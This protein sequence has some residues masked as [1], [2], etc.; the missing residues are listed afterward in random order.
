MKDLY[1]VLRDDSKWIWDNLTKAALE[2]VGDNPEF[3][4]EQPEWAFN[5]SGLVE[6]ITHWPGGYLKR[7]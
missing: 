6:N 1:D 2:F 7:T 3:V 5:E 4:I